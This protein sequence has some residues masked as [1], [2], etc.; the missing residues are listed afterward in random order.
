MGAESAEIE[1]TAVEVEESAD[2]DVLASSAMFDVDACW[3]YVS[4]SASN[5]E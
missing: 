5:K 3:L 4:S 2:S 1:S